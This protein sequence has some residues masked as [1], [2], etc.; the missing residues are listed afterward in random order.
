MYSFAAGAPLVV[1]GPSLIAHRGPIT[2]LDLAAMLAAAAAAGFSGVSVAQ[3]HHDSVVAAGMTTSEF[4]ELHHANGLSIPTVEV[5]V[6]WAGAHPGRACRADAA[7]VD[8]AAAAGASTVIAACLEPN[9]PSVGEL[10]RS[11]AALCDLAA[12]RGVEVALEFLPWT[13]IPTLTAAL[14]VVAA[15]GRDNLGLVLDAWHWFRQPGGPAPGI[16]RAVAPELIRVVQ[17]DDAPRV[18]GTL[19]LRDEALTARLLPGDGDVD[20]GALLDAV[21]EIGAL[22]IIAS[23]VFSTALAAPG[24]AHAADAQKAALLG[25]LARGG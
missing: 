19:S 1:S 16:L 10:G 11:L 5:A 15:A 20:L 12:E 17:L 13:A 6:G 3:R 8:L 9:P 23:E 4:V 18:P 7:L 21:D 2:G 22:P 24:P 14:D 25:V